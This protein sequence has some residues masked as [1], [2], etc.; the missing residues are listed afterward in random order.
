MTDLL[1]RRRL[2]RSIDQPNLL[3]YI[4]TTLN[5]SFSLNHRTISSNVDQYQN[6]ILDQYLLY[7]L[8]QKINPN[9]LNN[10]TNDFYQL[11]HQ[12]IV[13]DEK[14]SKSFFE[15][16]N[17]TTIQSYLNFIWN[18][19]DVLTLLELGCFLLKYRLVD[20]FANRQQK[21]FGFFFE[22]ISIYFLSNYHSEYFQN[23]RS[24]DMIFPSPSVYLY[25]SSSSS[26]LA[27]Q[28][29]VFKRFQQLLHDN[30]ENH[31]DQQTIRRFL[32]NNTTY[33]FINRKLENKKSNLINFMEKTII[34]QQKNTCRSLKS[35]CR[36]VIK[37]NLRQYPDDVKQLTLYSTMNE[38][39]QNFL[40][41]SNPFVFESTV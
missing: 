27:D 15:Y 33:Q 39:L 21:I 6:T 2:F 5:E 32:H 30:G 1:T 8:C 4:D 26:T 28:Q 19:F 7:L 16:S 41:F 23:S 36:I 25:A 18:E 10:L 12:L 40:V 3:E 35:L 24:I 11:L 13:L 38:Q 9:R 20:L 31:F 22:I 29:I 37:T 34:Y 14:I 17:R